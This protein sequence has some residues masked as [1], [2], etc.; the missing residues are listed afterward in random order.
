MR[1]PTAKNGVKFARLAAPGKAGAVP[2]FVLLG[3]TGTRDVSPEEGFREKVDGRR[4]PVPVGR[5]A[6]E[7]TV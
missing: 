1:V 4:A 2:V 5:A 6:P 3:A 7:L